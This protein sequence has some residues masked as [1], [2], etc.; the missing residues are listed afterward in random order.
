MLVTGL[1]SLLFSF[2]TRT[3]NPRIALPTM[4][5]AQPNQSLVKKMPTDL[6]EAFTQLKLPPL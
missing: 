2:R 6:K 5:W 4:G 3:T 1:L